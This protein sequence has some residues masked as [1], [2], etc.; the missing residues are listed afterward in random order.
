MSSFLST[1]H[2]FQNVTPD[3]EWS[4]INK[5]GKTNTLPKTTN[6]FVQK[7]SI[8]ETLTDSQP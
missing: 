1:T 5:Q 2:E 4:I 3:Y 8:L 6:K 7:I